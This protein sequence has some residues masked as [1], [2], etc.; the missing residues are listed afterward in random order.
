MLSADP[1]HTAEPNSAILLLDRDHLSRLVREANLAYRPM[2]HPR[3]DAWVVHQES[4]EPCLLRT[5]SSNGARCVRYIYCSKV[6]SKCLMPGHVARLHGTIAILCALGFDSLHRVRSRNQHVHSKL[7]HIE[8]ELPMRDGAER[9]ASVSSDHPVAKV[10]LREV[11]LWCQ[12]NTQEFHD[13]G[14]SR[15]TR[16]WLPC[17]FVSV[18]LDGASQTL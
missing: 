13:Q 12:L 4:I 5:T 15:Y 6:C 8:N 3:M 9:I 11:R 17:G 1:P 10:S 7:Q 16:P 14:R 18:F 2:A